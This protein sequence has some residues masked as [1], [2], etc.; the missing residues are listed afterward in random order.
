[1]EEVECYEPHLLENAARPEKRSFT[2]KNV[3]LKYNEHM[4][5]NKFSL[6]VL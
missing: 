4:A 5:I 3:T 6:Y 1:M 2:M